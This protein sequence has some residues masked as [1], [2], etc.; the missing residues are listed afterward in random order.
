MRWSSLLYAHRT[1]FFDLGKPNTHVRKTIRGNAFARDIQGRLEAPA[2]LTLTVRH[3]FDNFTKGPSA[4]VA[5]H[6]NSARHASSV[7]IYI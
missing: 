4:I 7:P 3:T 6:Y 1:L 2:K 5:L